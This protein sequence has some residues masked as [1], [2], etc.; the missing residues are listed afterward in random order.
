M[1]IDLTSKS[2]ELKAAGIDILRV[3][4]VDVLGIARS[5]DLLV[6]ELARSAAH[7][8]AFC[9]G[10]WITST[11]GGVI[12]SGHA[13]LADGLPDLLT[14]IDWPTLRTIPWEPGV[15][16]V[17][18][19]AL[20]PDG[21]PNQVSPRTVLGNVLNQYKSLGLTPVAGPELE[22]Y[23][24]KLDEHGQ[25]KR[26]IEKTGRVYMTGALVDP[27]G[28]FL[29]MLRNLGEFNIGTFAGNHE[30]SPSQYEINL[31]HSEAMDAADRTFLLKYAVKDIAARAGVFA[32]FMGK[33]WN[34]E[35]GSGFHMHVSLVDK[36]GKNVM[37]AGS[38]LSETTLHFIGGV[39]KHAPA[40]TALTNPTVNSYRRIRPNSL[41]P[42]RIN[43]GFDNR[44]TYMR[45]PP[46]RGEGTRIEV[47][48]ADGAAN[49][50]LVMAAIFAAGL[51]GIKKKITPPEPIAG[52][53]YDDEIAAVL[54]GTLA[55]ALDELEAN[56]VLKDAL[57]ELLFNSFIALKR[58]EVDRYN[59]HVSDWEIT[60]YL[61]DF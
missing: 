48:V 59:Q 34:D 26:A 22:F 55:K 51:D 16:I 7:G 19:H 17:I 43:W 38:E 2:N 4:Y 35:G 61:E 23:I 40:M 50:Y 11:V 8:P 29:S 56:D 27:N 10:V 3:A 32:T 54:P 24:A 37:H 21:T 57:G 60:E 6:S 13:S 5:K 33:P 39:I 12:E 41:A 46:E 45:I 42:Y 58:D 44:S 30:F 47:R 49:A 20:D 9:Q 52:W 14:D 15:A 53:A 1:S 31:W 28:L 25:F 36:N 18:A